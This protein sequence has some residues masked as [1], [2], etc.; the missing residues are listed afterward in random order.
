MHASWTQRVLPTVRMTSSIRLH[1]QSPLEALITK[2]DHLN[3]HKASESWPRAAK[4]QGTVSHS[5]YCLFSE[6]NFSDQ[7]L[8]EKLLLVNGNTTYRF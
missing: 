8:T 7:S 1:L 4:M 5:N 2:G 6:V 3:Q